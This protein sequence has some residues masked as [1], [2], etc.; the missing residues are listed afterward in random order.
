MEEIKQITECKISDDE[1]LE[2]ITKLSNE[3]RE[4]L[5]TLEFG[6]IRVIANDPK[7]GIECINH[8]AGMIRTCENLC[9]AVVMFNSALKDTEKSTDFI[10]KKMEGNYRTF[11]DEEKLK[12][13]EKILS[14]NNSEVSTQLFKNTWKKFKWQIKELMKSETK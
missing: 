4:A 2:A 12:F 10:M 3:D 7:K 6:V 14:M 1:I 11:S 13:S 9:T 5:L 8:W